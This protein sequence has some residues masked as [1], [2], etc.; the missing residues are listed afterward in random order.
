MNDAE[1][2]RIEDHREDVL[3][4]LEDAHPVWVCIRDVLAESK[5]RSVETV[6]RESMTAE[7][8]AYAAGY[9][10]AAVDVHEELNRLR[11]A[12]LSKEVVN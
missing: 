3:G 1:R 12:H 8:R 10:A 2:Q 4:T 5:D 6:T 11:K 9:L 7:E